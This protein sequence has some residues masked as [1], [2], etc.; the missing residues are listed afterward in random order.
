M[1]VAKKIGS[2]LCQAG[3]SQKELSQKTGISASK[4]RPT[5][6][7]SRRLTYDEYESICKALGVDITTFLEACEP[8][9][10]QV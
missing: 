10:A 4:I 1:K 5:L 7:G 9:N 3:I 8:E 6:A 2:F